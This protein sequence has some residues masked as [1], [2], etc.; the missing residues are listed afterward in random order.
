MAL[1]P[2]VHFPDIGAYIRVFNSLTRNKTEFKSDIVVAVDRL[3]SDF[4]RVSI[5]PGFIANMT[6]AV[7][8]IS[9]GES[10]LVAA[11]TDYHT[12]ILRAELPSTRTTVSG[13]ITDLFA[14]MGEYGPPQTFME[15]GNFHRFFR[16]RYTRE[17]VPVAPSGVNTVD[18]SLGD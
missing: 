5:L 6:A 1:Q 18:D 15:G 4:A 14:A 17:D 2:E 11:S 7:N 16:D 13:V 12:T 9:N 10:N 3:G 8:S